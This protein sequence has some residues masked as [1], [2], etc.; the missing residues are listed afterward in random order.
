MITA[1]WLTAIGT[2]GTFFVICASAIAAVRQLRHMRSANQLQGILALEE[3]FRDPDLQAA[4]TYA[5][6][7]LPKKLQDATYRDE[8]EHR[9][10]IDSQ[11][12]PELLLLNWF[13]KMGLL[14]KHRIVSEDAFMDL[15]A[16]LIVYYWDLLAPAVAL[17]RRTRGEG[18]YHDFEYLALRGRAWLERNR[19]GVF[20]K[21]VVRSKLPDSFTP[22]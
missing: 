18:E 17:M 9:G 16:R 5:Q 1:E 14:V 6:E 2:L 11:K 22:L 3:H 21:G 8:L 20:P 15:F 13:N 4:L 19:A 10:Y 12:H 7:M